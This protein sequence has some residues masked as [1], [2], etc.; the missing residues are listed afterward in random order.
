MSQELLHKFLVEFREL[1]PK[2]VII[3]HGGEPMAAGL[4]FYQKAFSIE[5]ELW[6]PGQVS[7]LMQTNGTLITPEWAKF[8]K[9][10]GLGI[11]VSMDGCPDQH[12][13]HRKTDKGKGSHELA[14][15]GIRLLQKYD[16]GFG[17]IQTVT[18]ETLPFAA[19][20]FD[21]LHDVVGTHSFS[22]NVYRAM[23][24][25]D[26]WIKSHNVSDD[27]WSGYMETIFEKW[28]VADDPKLIVREIETA[29][30]GA[31][32]RL[33]RA[34]RY[35]GSCG[36]Y[37]CLEPDGRIYPCDRFM[38]ESYQWGD[39]SRQHLRDILESERRV[40]FLRANEE[41]YLTCGDCG[42]FK[43][44][45]NGCGSHRIGGVSGHFYY[46]HSTGKTFET[47]QSAIE[48]LLPEGGD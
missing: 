5:E 33:T 26:E 48:K 45:H 11:G 21:Y 14:L 19:Q 36:N 34:C 40:W 29:V 30:Q 32:S 23:G 3:W 44:C 41:S 35:N 22:L 2:A 15:R 20:S 9:A 10:S 6:E 4:D 13:T 12:N 43:S 8:I 25:D 38:D 1:A 47:V 42:W 17:V 37:L 7:N 24:S 28:M 27:D 46:C 16:V 31:L 39:L 18:N